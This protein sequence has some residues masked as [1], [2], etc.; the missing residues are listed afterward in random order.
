M[1]AALLLA[2]GTLIVSLGFKHYLSFQTQPRHRVLWNSMTSVLV[3]FSFFLSGLFLMKLA[4]DYSRITF[5]FQLVNV[6]IAVMTFRMIAHSRLRLAIAEERVAARR[7]IIIGEAGDRALIETQLGEAGVR[8]V[9]TL[10]IPFAAVASN[11]ANVGLAKRQFSQLVETCRTVKPDDIVILTATA[12]LARSAALADAL[13]EL[14]VSV[15]MVPIDTAA[16][17]GSSRLGELGAM[18]TLE[19][20]RP[21]LSGADKA[22][23]R[24]F[25]I[26][27]ASCGLV[28]LLPL[29]LITAVAIKLDSRGPILF[30]QTRHGYNNETIRVFKFRSMN[31]VEDG[32]VFTQA[33]KHDPRVTRVGQFLRKSNVDELP[34]LLNV[35][36]GEM[37]IVGPRPHPIALNRV[38]EQHITPL[39]RRHNVKPGITG[40]AQVNGHRGETDT[41]DK[42]RRRIECDMYYIDNW[43]F[44]LDFK[45][46]LMTV[47]SKSAYRNAF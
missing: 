38:F 34:Q 26:V 35:L 42:M 28:L 37:S 4:T 31:T 10:P 22:L 30:R 7:A 27:A 23:K 15:H 40:W 33:K 24:L 32:T 13:S 20:N 5:L 18:V 19:L 3:T 17:F 8:T 47:F 21:S 41:I 25:D 44:S 12:D 36:K 39:W 6:S 29:L 46:I 14:P 16:L 2:A 11:A 9:R 45:I 43:S 1:V